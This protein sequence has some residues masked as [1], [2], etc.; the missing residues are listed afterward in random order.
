VP[1]AALRSLV[2]GFAMNGDNAGKERG[3]GPGAPDDLSA[4]LERLDKQLAGR[5]APPKASGGSDRASTSPSALGRAFRLSTEFVAGVIAGGLLGWLFDR[6]LG[7]SPWGMIVFLMLGFA[8]G[9]YNV[10]RASGFMDP[11]SGSKPR[12]S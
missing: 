7:T 12:D 5:G 9:I 1:R 11:P 2:D 6:M 3:N 4:R 8:A 10:M